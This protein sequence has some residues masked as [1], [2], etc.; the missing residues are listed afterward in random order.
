MKLAQLCFSVSVLY[1]S[2]F[3]SYTHELISI[4]F[5]PGARENGDAN[6]N[7]GKRHGGRR[8]EGRIPRVTFYSPYACP[9]LTHK[10]G[11]LFYEEQISRK[12]FPD[13]RAFRETQ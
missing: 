5:S 12:K 1:P 13:H 2:I 11:R 10:T 8:P 7:P 9:H 3:L 4:A 6:A